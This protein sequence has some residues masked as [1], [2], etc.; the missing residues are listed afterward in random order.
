M[1]FLSNI[2]RN[3]TK[4]TIEGGYRK[5]FNK[6]STIQ[7]A[8]SKGKIV[9]VNDVKSSRWKRKDD[10]LYGPVN[11]I[12]YENAIETSVSSTAV[13][14]VKYDPKTQDLDIRYVGGD[15][16]YTFPNVPEDVFTEFMDAPSKG[17]YLAYVIKPQYSENM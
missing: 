2:L 14:D 9:Q 13:A 1:G 5:D 16:Y 4:T 8:I 10:T 11:N 12:D 7:K 6:Q 17:R 15:I 3:I